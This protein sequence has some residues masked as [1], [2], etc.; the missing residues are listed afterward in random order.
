MYEGK[1]NI[2]FTKPFGLYLLFLRIIHVPSVYLGWYVRYDENWKF[3]SNNVYELCVSSLN[4]LSKKTKTKFHVIQN[5][6]ICNKAGVCWINN[7]LYKL[8]WAQNRTNKVVHFGAKFLEL[9]FLIKLYLERTLV[10]K[11]KWIH[12]LILNHFKKIIVHNSL[13]FFFFNDIPSIPVKWLPF[14]QNHLCLSK[15]EGKVCIEEMW[16]SV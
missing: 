9:F 6:L 13:S 5:D 8:Y 10:G 4:I 7:C 2:L 15:F 16:T 11:S 14:L 1:H 3:C 12:C